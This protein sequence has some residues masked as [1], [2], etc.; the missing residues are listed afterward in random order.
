MDV[1][2]LHKGK[3]YEE[4]PDSLIIFICP[5]DPLGLGVP[6][7]TF[8]RRCRQAPNLKV[9][10][11]TC[12][13]VLNAPYWRQVPVGELRDL[14]RYI[15][16]EGVP[17]TSLV[18]EIDAA[19]QHANQDDLWRREAVQL[20]TLEQDMASQ[21]NISRRE[22]KAEGKAEMAALVRLLLEEGRT[23]DLE[24]AVRDRAFCDE[25]LA[26]MEAGQ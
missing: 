6:L 9:D 26:Q 17:E 7:A 10:D 20:L 14:L 12:W 5:N 21:I 15:A 22:G 3:G 19:V 23:D 16:Q 11:G 4:L 25:L 18:Q 2:Y 8:V 24:R 13:K 1:A